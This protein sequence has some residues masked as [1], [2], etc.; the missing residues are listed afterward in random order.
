MPT[1]KEGVS[2]NADNLT[3]EQ[4]RDQTW[5]D[6]IADED[7]AEVDR[8]VQQLRYTAF[9]KLWDGLIAAE[10]EEMAP[11]LF[12]WLSC[13]PNISEADR[14][15]GWEIPVGKLVSLLREFGPRR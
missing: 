8:L 1:V 10:P 7:V 14:A 2:V 3:L 4:F 9:N 5:Q 12:C 15:L 11:A 13:S 6:D